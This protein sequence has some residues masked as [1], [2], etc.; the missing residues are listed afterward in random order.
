ML[1]FVQPL[2]AGWQLI[3]F[4]RG[5]GAMNP[6]AKVWGRND[7][8]DRWS[9]SAKES[10]PMIAP[11]PGMRRPGQGGMYVAR[12]VRRGRALQGNG[13]RSAKLACADD[14]VGQAMIS[15]MRERQALR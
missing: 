6:A 9:P 5:H 11:R 7:M 15:L 14:L 13:C 4:G 3:G 8:P 10:S 12:I 1:D 2:A